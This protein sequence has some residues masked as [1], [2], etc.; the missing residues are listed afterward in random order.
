MYG[1]VCVLGRGGGFN[2]AKRGEK[3]VRNRVYT[4]VYHVVLGHALGTNRMSY[5]GSYTHFCHLIFFL[6]PHLLLL[7]PPLL[8]PNILSFL[9]FL[10]FPLCDETTPPHSMTFLDGH[11]AGT[12]R[13]PSWGRSASMPWHEYNGRGLWKVSGQGLWEF[14]GW[15]ASNRVRLSQH[16]CGSKVYF[17]YGLTPVDSLSHSNVSLFVS[18][19]TPS[20]KFLQCA[21]VWS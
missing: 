13:A 15:N 18:R 21:C 9:S 5:M 12:G 20:R 6:P 4:T 17:S 2:A 11:S 14:P 7:L 1:A 10:S 8:S 16:P 3:R 19:C